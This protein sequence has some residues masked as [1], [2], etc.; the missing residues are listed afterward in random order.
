VEAWEG[1]DWNNDVMNNI[2]GDT[3]SIPH[4]L[5]KMEKA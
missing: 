4:A 3:L 2:E 1:A 5:E